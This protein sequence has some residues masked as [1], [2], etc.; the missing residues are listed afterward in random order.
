MSN[1]I[2]KG[3]ITN[4]EY[5]KNLLDGIRGNLNP[6]NVSDFEKTIKEYNESVEKLIPIIR[7]NLEMPDL[8]KKYNKVI[9]ETSNKNWLDN[10]DISSNTLA[11]IISELR[12]EVNKDLKKAA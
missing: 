11:S 9:I 10:M 1:E 12:E 2:I 4:T 6:A 3:I 8:V 5:L 7:R